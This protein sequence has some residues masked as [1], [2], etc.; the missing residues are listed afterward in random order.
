MAKDLANNEHKDAT[1]SRA[2]PKKGATADQQSHR[3]NTPASRVNATSARE[4]PSTP[5]PPPPPADSARPSTPAADA[6]VDGRGDRYNPRTPVRRAIPLDENSPPPLSNAS[7]QWNDA[8]RPV[9]AEGLSRRASLSPIV[10]AGNNQRSPETRRESPCGERG[11][12]LPEFFVEDGDAWFIDLFGDCNAPAAEGEQR[13]ND[14]SENDNDDEGETPE[15]AATSDV[16]AANDGVSAED[17][18]AGACAEPEEETTVDDG[19][20]DADPGENL[21]TDHAPEDTAPPALHDEDEDAEGEEDVFCEA[22]N[23]PV[24]HFPEAQL[25]S[26]ALAH[27]Q[28]SAAT[29]LAAAPST[30]TNDNDV[31]PFSQDDAERRLGVQDDEHEAAVS[32]SDDALTSAGCHHDE[33][34]AERSEPDVEE[35]HT[36]C[37]DHP[38]LSEKAAGKRKRADTPPNEPIGLDVEQADVRSWTPEEYAQAVALQRALEQEIRKRLR[39][40]G[41]QDVSGQPREGVASGSANALF[42]SDLAERAELHRTLQS[43][44]Q[45]SGTSAAQQPPRGT[46]QPHQLAPGAYAQNAAIQ[47]N[48]PQGSQAPPGAPSQGTD[49]SLQNGHFAPVPQQ[50]PHAPPP[51]LRHPAEAAY[52]ADAQA[53]QHDHSQYAPLHAGPARQQIPYSAPAPPYPVTTSSAGPLAPP[54]GAMHAGGMGPPPQMGYFQGQGGQA[55]GYL[56]AL[57]PYPL[58]LSS[59][60]PANQ[61]LAAWAQAQAQSSYVGSQYFG[62][63]HASSAG[64]SAPQPPVPVPPQASTSF[65]G[66]AGPAAPGNATGNHAAAAPSSWI[67]AV[68]DAPFAPPAPAPSTAAEAP[69]YFLGSLLSPPPVTHDPARPHMRKCLWRHWNPA[70][71]RQEW[72]GH[73]FDLRVDLLGQMKAHYDAE[74]WPRASSRARCAWYGCEKGAGERGKRTILKCLKEH[75][76]S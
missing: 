75:M 51:A 45:E 26:L 44:Q 19:T 27:F 4:R 50:L 1:K 21:P 62:A 52:V 60:A 22:P 31:C 18:V 11:Y 59:H 55:Q 68:D 13:V 28:A 17:A 23:G 39:T 63:P 12:R 30:H 49:P 15:T 57:P 69:R 40:E 73:W 10:G 72:C 37:K 24:S 41:D 5:P 32:A 61:M 43:A 74:V 71:E 2:P 25:L 67:P 54:A 34:E 46:L 35:Q 48:D 64:Q 36:E 38:V 58:Q 65:A 6:G 47:G 20:D 8:L 16:F 56:S 70:T 76:T 33:H 53:H 66:G 29:N 42:E 3:A 14:A 7:P 9:G